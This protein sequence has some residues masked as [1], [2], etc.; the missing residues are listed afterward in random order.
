MSRQQHVVKP[1]ACISSWWS[2]NDCGEQGISSA[3]SHKH[4][5]ALS[6]S[7]NVVLPPTPQVKKLRRVLPTGLDKRKCIT[8]LGCL[9]AAAASYILLGRADTP[10]SCLQR[11][12]WISVFHVA[13][14]CRR[15]KRGDPNITD[16]SQLC[17]PPLKGCEIFALAVVLEY[18]L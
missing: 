5:R 4:T 8:F 13:E 15:S 16:L 12:S 2:D 18:E 11:L 10:P 6:H 7:Q 9:R 1:E 14:P 17:Q 3:S